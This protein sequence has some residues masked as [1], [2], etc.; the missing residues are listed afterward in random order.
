M[1]RTTD[2]EVRQIIELDD[3]IDTEPF[4]EGAN[5]I[6]T[7]ICASVLQDDGVTPFHTNSRL[8]LIERWLAAH[9]AATL[10]PRAHVEQVG[11][12][13]NHFESKVELRLQNSAWGQQALVFD[14]SGALAAY[15]NGLDKV[16]QPEFQGVEEP[17]KKFKI[18]WLGS[19]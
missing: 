5:E 8:K 1:P 7:E 3:D 15:N 2:E 11:L 16:T 19:E 14:T 12:I 13:R 6:V 18:R 17:G 4:I 9:F 10:G